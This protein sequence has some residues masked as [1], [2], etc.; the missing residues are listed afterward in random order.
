ML[1]SGW[2]WFVLQFLVPLGIVPNALIIVGTIIIFMFHNFFSSR[3]RPKYVSLS[4]FSLIFSLWSAGT[5][6]S[7]IRQVLI[8]CYLSLSLVYW[9]WI[10]DLR[11]FCVSHSPRRILVCAYTIWYYGQISISCTIPGGPSLPHTV[12]SSLLLFL[13]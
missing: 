11:E 6:K 7:T 3:A 2:S 5:V 4:S 8:F 13:S 12:V 9:P 1:L 10:W